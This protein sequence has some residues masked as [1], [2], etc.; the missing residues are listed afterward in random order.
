MGGPGPGNLFAVGTIDLATVAV[1][2]GA[3]IIATHMLWRAGSRP[4]R[5]AIG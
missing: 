5:R 1:L 2:A 3:L 4:T